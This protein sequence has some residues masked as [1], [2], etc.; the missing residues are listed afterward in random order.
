MFF[1]V[2]KPYNALMARRAKEDGFRILEL[3]AAHGYLMNEFLSP[4][5]NLR[6]DRYGGSLENRTRMVR[7]VVAAV[8]EAWPENLPLFLR[9]SATDWVEGGWDASQTVE[10]ARQVA[11]LGVDLIDCSSGGNVAHTS[12]PLGPGYQVRFAEQVRRESGI[13]TGAVGMIT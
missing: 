12:I 7:E 9:V 1:F 2:V 11:K 5:S 13:A 3:H 8:R 6:Q 10:L 4:L